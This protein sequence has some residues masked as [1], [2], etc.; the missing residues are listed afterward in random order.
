MRRARNSRASA[1]RS[2]V[3]I[4]SAC[5]SPMTRCET[6]W[7]EATKTPKTCLARANPSRPTD[8]VLG[9]ANESITVQNLIVQYVRVSPFDSNYRTIPVTGEGD[10]VYFV[11]G[12]TVTGKWETSD[13]ERPHHLS[14]LRRNG[15]APGARQHMDYDDAE[16]GR[17]PGT[18]RGLGSTITSKLT[19][20]GR[21]AGVLICAMLLFRRLIVP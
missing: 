17:Y 18:L 21:F 16:S 3:P 12:R 13:A 11:N 6:C 8:D 15:A 5:C 2:P 1:S 10:C 4:P 19:N 9:Y 20:A 14:A 7:C